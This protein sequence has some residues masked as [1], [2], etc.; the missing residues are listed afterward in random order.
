MLTG[1]P[2]YPMPGD[3]T[4]EIIVNVILYGTV[5]ALLLSMLWV[6]VLFLKERR[7]D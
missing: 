6:V 3:P 4:G 7:Q 5:L 1:L 2:A